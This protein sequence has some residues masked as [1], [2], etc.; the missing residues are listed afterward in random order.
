MIIYQLRNLLKTYKILLIFKC[1]RNF[2]IEI[3]KLEFNKNTDLNIINPGSVRI[4]RLTRTEFGVSGDIYL[5]KSINNKGLVDMIINRVAVGNNPIQVHRKQGKL[6]DF[7]QT[8]DQFYP[9]LVKSS[10]FPEPQCPFPKVS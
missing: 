5:F 1:K 3:T 6:C 7:I 2:D 8:D 9:K 10:N 4:A